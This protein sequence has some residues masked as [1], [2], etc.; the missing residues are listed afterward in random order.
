M[1][2]AAAV[3]VVVVCAAMYTIF[4]V[5]ERRKRKKFAEDIR[6]YIQ[7]HK[8]EWTGDNQDLD[9]ANEVNGNG[10]VTFLNFNGFRLWGNNTVAYPSNTDPKDRFI[11]ARRFLSYDD[12]NFILTNFG[13]VDMRTNPRLREAVIDQQ[14][15]IGASYISAEI[16]ARY[17]MEFLSSENTSETLADGKMYFHKHVAMYL[18]AE[19]IEEI[20]EFDINAITAA[21][22]K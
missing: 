22:S 17:E 21:M 16:C 9:Q 12:N 20:V 18:P 7:N 11:S 5:I 10:V 1:M 13:N 3:T 14:N 15:T 4:E 2:G 19:D 6:R 8:G